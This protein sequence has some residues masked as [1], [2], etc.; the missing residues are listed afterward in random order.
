[1]R[2]GW[3]LSSAANGSAQQDS[4]RR[5]RET[6]RQR[7]LEQTDLA[8][9]EILKE[10]DQAGIY[11]NMSWDGRLVMY[12]CALG[13]VFQLCS[14]AALDYDGL[15][16]ALKP[17][18]ELIRRRLYWYAFVHEGITTGLKGGR[19]V[20]DED[21][22]SSLEDVLPASTKLALAS[23]KAYQSVA[24]FASAPIRLS[25][26]CR[27]VHKALT[28]ARARRSETVDRERLNEAWEALEES[29]V[30][31]DD[32]KRFSPG[33]IPDENRI[34]FADGWKIFMFEA[35]NVIRESLEHRLQS[36]QSK[37]REAAQ[38]EDL[39]MDNRTRNAETQALFEIRNL[40]DIAW[41]KCD[42]LVKEIASVIKQH[43]HTPFFEWD[44]SL[45]R[46]GIYYV[47]SLLAQSGGADQDI[48]RCAQALSEMRWAFAKSEE[49]TER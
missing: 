29:W 4:V 48:A 11:R 6:A 15:P 49:R 2:Y 34:R 19:M 3:H 21:D 16:Q 33:H 22:L 10:I 45:V 7:Q 36:L 23:S 12:E 38:F 39:S 17:E 25:I 28:G 40:R 24:K 37:A 26:A 43:L 46:D 41:A 31:F 9:K 30:E 44:A 14:A 18:D 20:L 8:V 27:L 35:H 5:D 32:I 13:Q 47:A 42:H 1:M